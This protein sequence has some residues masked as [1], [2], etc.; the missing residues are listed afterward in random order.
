MTPFPFCFGSFGDFQTKSHL[1]ISTK[2]I[3]SSSICTD[4]FCQKLQLHDEIF[5]QLLP[6]VS[7]HY[8]KI[9]LHFS[10]ERFALHP[11]LCNHGIGYTEEGTFKNLSPQIPG[12]SPRT[13]PAT[14]T[15]TQPIQCPGCDGSCQGCEDR[16]LPNCKGCVKRVL[17]P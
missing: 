7:N 14:Q 16:G 1:T 9:P 13:N 12:F 5:A 10:L 15:H 3:F 17:Y 4:S 8:F 6:T 11:I 2:S